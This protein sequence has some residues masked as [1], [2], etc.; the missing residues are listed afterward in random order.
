M[1]VAAW[2]V[3]AVMAMAADLDNGLGH[4]SVWPELLEL[5]RMVTLGCSGVAL[6]PGGGWWFLFGVKGGHGRT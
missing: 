5:K 2:L 6:P 4:V 1:G 3:A